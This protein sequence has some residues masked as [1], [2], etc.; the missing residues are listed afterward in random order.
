[1]IRSCLA[2]IILG[3]GSL[4]GLALPATAQAADAYRTSGDC[5][6]FPRVPVETPP[7]L[8]VGLVASKLG[9]ARGVTAVGT[10][11]YLIDMG[12]WAKG[13]GRL[14]RLPDRGRGPA[15]VLLSGLDR[16]NGLIQAGD[17]RLLV[18]V[19][20]RV[21]SVDPKADNP[22]ASARD[23]VTGLP[24]DGRHPLSAMALAPDGSL[25]VNAGS[26]TDH[27]EGKRDAAPDPAKP[28]P[29][30]QARPPRAS[31]LK[32]TPGPRPVDARPLTPF[33]RG[34]RNS[35][36]LW[37]LPNGT[38]LA[39]VNAR[40]AIDQA[41]P[42]LSDAAL[43]HDFYAVLAEGADYGWPYCY[44]DR[45][46]SP[47]YPRFDCA[48][49]QP[50]TLLLP[51]HAAPLGMLVYGGTA[52]PGLT[53]RLII[54]YHGYRDDGHTVTALTIDE[55]GRPQGQ[56]EPV[57]WSWD[58]VKG[59]HPQ[60]SPV[61]LAEMDDGSILITEDHNGTLLRLSRAE[62]PPPPAHVEPRPASN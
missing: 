13:R 22:S 41:D 39:A 11:V 7:G 18:G 32:L 30:T 2:L 36:A 25:F 31:V 55:S 20:G 47:E 34:L 1:M 26:G 29:E 44:D 54:G 48:K 12:G 14:L 37:V 8:C 28:C 33:A 52:L 56:P 4:I 49:M 3:F 40:D 61:A 6:G 24:N 17:G 38:P 60:G 5:D 62:A 59:I 19:V 16:P 58:A 15:Q 51:P 10:D 50:P 46:P 53:G 35:M 42:S 21:I 27:C 23:I 9:F 43:P 45:K 57:I